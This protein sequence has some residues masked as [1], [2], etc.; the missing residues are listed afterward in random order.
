MYKVKSNP[1]TT[2]TTVIE[3]TRGATLFTLDVQVSVEN[4]DAINRLCY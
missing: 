3:K 1:N 4:Q 2:V